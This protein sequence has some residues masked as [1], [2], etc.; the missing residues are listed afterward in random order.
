M[1]RSFWVHRGT[2]P[3]LET[4]LPERPTLMSLTFFTA[5][6]SSA[7]SIS[8]LLDELALPHE[9]V[10]L[11]LTKG[12]S[13]TPQLLALN[14]NGKVPT[15]VVDGTPVFEALA[16]AQYLGDRHG[17]AK[18]LWPAF[19]SASRLEAISWTA[20]TYV[21]YY[22]ALLRLVASASASPAAAGAGAATAGGTQELLGI[23]DGRLAKAPWMLGAEFSLV[24]S[25]MAN[26]VKFGAYCGASFDAHPHVSAW[27]TKNAA[28]PAFKKHWGG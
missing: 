5:P 26:V 27:M 7:T 20:W 11:D 21:T 19:D 16:I 18:G 28:R 15:L 10:V 23:L 12:E 25:L 14:P 17:V 3:R 4:A 22:P 24:D 2:T 13:R 6:N 1:V 9:A 8:V